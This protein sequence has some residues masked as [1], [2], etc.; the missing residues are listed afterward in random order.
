MG[1]LAGVLGKQVEVR[2]DELPLGIRD[3]AGVRLV[4][5]HALKYVA[6]W[7]RVHYAL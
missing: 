5:D 1:A 6:N 4:S 2:D 7:T 3:V